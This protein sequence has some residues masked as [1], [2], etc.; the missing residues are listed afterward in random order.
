M[1]LLGIEFNIW[2]RELDDL[3]ALIKSGK[4]KVVAEGQ[5]VN[6]QNIQ[7]IV[8]ETDELTAAELLAQH[9]HGIGVER[10]DE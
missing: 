7:A 8:L 1:A 2:S 6:S 10:L 9:G 4:A 3:H 5:A